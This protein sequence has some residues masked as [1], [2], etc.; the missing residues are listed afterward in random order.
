MKNRVV[1]TADCTLI[2]EVAREWLSKLQTKVDTI[3]ER[4]KIHTLEIKEIERR[5]KNKTN[6]TANIKRRSKDL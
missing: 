1:L 3:N 5:L 4:T 2:D 6:G